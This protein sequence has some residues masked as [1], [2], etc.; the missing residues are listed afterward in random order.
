VHATL[1]GVVTALFVPLRGRGGAAPFEA[2][3]DGL[4]PWVA[5]GVMPVFAFANA[6]VPLAGIAPASLLEGVPLAIVLGL[7]A[8]K[9]MG[10]LGASAIAVAA[11]A[12]SLPAGVSWRHMAGVSLLCG[13]GFTMSLF[14][15]GLAFENA[16][17]AYMMQVRVG[18]LVGSMLSA[19]CGYG[20]LRWWAGR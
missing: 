7:L 18:V 13:I 1:A 14:I 12:A 11:G 2:I 19:I 10:V 3:E 17:P 5:F 20:I 9:V 8:G 4:A 6:G 15:G 16:D